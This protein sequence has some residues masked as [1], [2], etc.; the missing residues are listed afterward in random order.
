MNIKICKCRLLDLC[1][2]LDAWAPFVVW[3]DILRIVYGK[4]SVAHERSC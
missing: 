4:Y 2:T 1:V 3:L